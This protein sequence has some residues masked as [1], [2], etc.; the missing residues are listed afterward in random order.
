MQYMVRVELY[1][2]ASSE[3]YQSLHAAMAREAFSRTLTDAVTGK[4]YEALSG[5]YCTE[6]DKGGH[7]VHD[8]AVRAARTVYASFGVEVAGDGRLWFSNCREM[9][10]AVPSF[11]EQ[12]AKFAVQNPPTHLTSLLT[13]PLPLRH[14]FSEA[15][16]RK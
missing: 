13:S 4:Q 14:A 15:W 16:P 3:D 7:A 5:T 11:G 2:L 1:G 6:S 12:L 9:K 10:A 8:A